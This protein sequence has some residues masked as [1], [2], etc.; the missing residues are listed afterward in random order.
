LCVW[1]F[2]TETFVWILLYWPIYRLSALKY[3][4]LSV[5]DIGASLLYSHGWLYHSLH[6]YCQVKF[7]CF[8]NTQCFSFTKNDD[9]NIFMP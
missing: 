9:V 6:Q 7:M 4:E 1:A 2:N 8:L 3:K 5:M